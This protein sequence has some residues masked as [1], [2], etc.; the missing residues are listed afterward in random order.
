[1]Q[2]FMGIICKLQPLQN[3]LN[4]IVIPD[5]LSDKPFMLTHLLMGKQRWGGGFQA[6]LGGWH[7]RL[8]R[9]QMHLEPALPSRDLK[10]EGKECR[11]VNLSELHSAG[12]AVVGGEGQDAI[13]S[14]VVVVRKQVT[15]T[16]RQ[17]V[18]FLPVYTHVTILRR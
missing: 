8:P 15:E 3:D 18:G 2:I 1:M 7:L 12:A 17:T 10:D 9:A 11:L 5:H 16:D 6:P 14:G 13:S 4:Q